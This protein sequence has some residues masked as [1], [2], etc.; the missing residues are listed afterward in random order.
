MCRE[1][2]EREGLHPTEK[3]PTNHAT[4]P[5]RISEVR[6]LKITEIIFVIL[7]LE[8]RYQDVTRAMSFR[9]DVGDLILLFP[10]FGA[11]LRSLVVLA[12]GR[13]FLIFAWVGSHMIFSWVEKNLCLF[14]SVCLCVF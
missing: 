3:F 2:S 14:M 7:C 13:I 5:S 8:V 6:H 4:K 11:W 10:A 9:K 1:A 12:C